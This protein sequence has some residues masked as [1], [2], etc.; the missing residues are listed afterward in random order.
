MIETKDMI[1]EEIV[2]EIDEMLM[3]L[4]RLLRIQ[5]RVFSTLITKFPTVKKQKAQKEKNIQKKLSS[6]LPALIH[7]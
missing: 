2:L 7:K 1:R 5:Y 3:K 6:Q 4:D